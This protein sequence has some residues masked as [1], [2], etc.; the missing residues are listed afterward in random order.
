[1][2]DQKQI[3]SVKDRLLKKAAVV[4]RVLAT[5]DGQELLLMLKQEF[6]SKLDG[7]PHQM[8]MNLGR[9]DVIAWLEALNRV[10]PEGR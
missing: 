5:P 3:D 6:M 10:N 4:K 7:E 1:M 8:H 2:A 9:V